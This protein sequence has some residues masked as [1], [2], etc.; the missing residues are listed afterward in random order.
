M[1]I[2]SGKDAS[3]LSY[4]AR[5]RSIDATRTRRL[6]APLKG[7]A[8]AVGKALSGTGTNK[9]AS[10]AA[11]GLRIWADTNDKIAGNV[12]KERR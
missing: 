4:L 9:R 3:V 1:T 6:L 7:E 10:K 11:K 2:I 5:H 12:A 8:L